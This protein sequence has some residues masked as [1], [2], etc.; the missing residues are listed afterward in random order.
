MFAEKRQYLSLKTTVSFKQNDSIFCEERQY[1]FPTPSAPF[2]GDAECD[3]NRGRYF[4]SERTGAGETIRTTSPFN[5][6]G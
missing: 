1:L 5:R 2:V 3:R 4:T 6:R